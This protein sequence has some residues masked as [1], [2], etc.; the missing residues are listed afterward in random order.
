[1]IIYSLSIK[2]NFSGIL[3]IKLSHITDILALAEHRRK[4]S[5]FPSLPKE[6]TFFFTMMRPISIH[7]NEINPEDC[8]ELI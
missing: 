6:N 3:Y 7:R 1:M 5:S 8:L 4:Y 2:K